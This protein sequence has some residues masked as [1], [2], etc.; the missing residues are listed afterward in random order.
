ML[1]SFAAQAAEKKISE[2]N[3]HR[4]YKKMTLETKRKLYLTSTGLNIK[5]YDNSNKLINKFSSIKKKNSQTF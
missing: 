2:F 1:R 3:M 4:K 5:V